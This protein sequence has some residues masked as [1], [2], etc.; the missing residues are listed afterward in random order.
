[1]NSRGETPTRSGPSDLQGTRVGDPEWVE[2]LA[3]GKS[4]FPW[5]SDR[6]NPSENPDKI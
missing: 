5:T 1:V 6:G 4:T 2:I 3:I